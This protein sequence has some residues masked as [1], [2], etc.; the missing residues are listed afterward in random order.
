MNKKIKDVVYKMILEIENE[1]S[2]LFA[3]HRRFVNTILSIS[4]LQDVLS[5]L[6]LATAKVGQQLTS[7]HSKR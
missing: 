6:V 7:T 1:T 4:P 5:S 3:G 2:R